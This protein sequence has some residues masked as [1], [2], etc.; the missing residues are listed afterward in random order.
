MIFGFPSGPNLDRLRLNCLKSQVGCDGFLARAVEESMCSHWF[1]N[2]SEYNG[3]CPA[4]VSAGGGASTLR[5]SILLDR[6]EP[7]FFSSVHKD[8]GVD[9]FVAY[10]PGYSCIKYF[11]EVYLE[12]GLGFSGYIGYELPILVFLNF[13]TQGLGL[14]G[15]WAFTMGDKEDETGQS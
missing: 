10:F 12:G 15:L 9:S 13:H 8:L 11:T 2:S 5:R 4:L 6:S 7:P 3:I 14:W 1:Y